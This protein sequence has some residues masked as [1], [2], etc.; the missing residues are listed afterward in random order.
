MNKKQMIDS[1]IEMLKAVDPE[2]VEVINFD[3]TDYDD[4]SVGFSV[5]LTTP[6]KKEPT[7][8]PAIR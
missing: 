1:A 5:N 4:G 8:E 3:R 2:T 7:E 6:A